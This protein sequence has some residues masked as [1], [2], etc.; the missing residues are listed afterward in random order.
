MKN[1]NVTYDSITGKIIMFTFSEVTDNG[2]YGKLQRRHWIRLMI[3]Y[4]VEKSN[5]VSIRTDILIKLANM[6]NNLLK[7]LWIDN[8]KSQKRWQCRKNSGAQ[9][10]MLALYGNDKSGL[11]YIIIVTW[12]GL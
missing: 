3:N 10:K 12:N 1:K 7:I 6:I 11:Y 2:V 5:A 4:P 9:P 8:S